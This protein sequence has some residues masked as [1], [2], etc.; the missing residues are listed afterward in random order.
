MKSNKMASICLL[1]DMFRCNFW[2]SIVS[3]VSHDLSPGTKSILE[4]VEDLISLHF[5]TF[6]IIMYYSN[7]HMMLVEKIGL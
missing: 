3:C 6:G 2:I 5:T 1:S 7:L 4:V